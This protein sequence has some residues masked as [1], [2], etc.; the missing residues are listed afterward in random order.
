V[1]E[2]NL[3]VRA[4]TSFEEAVEWLIADG[5]RLLEAIG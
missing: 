4:F 3:P 1:T 5:P 2:G